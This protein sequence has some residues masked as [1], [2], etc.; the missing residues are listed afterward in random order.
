MVTS[1]HPAVCLGSWKHLL[2]YPTMRPCVMTSKT[3]I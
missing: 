1:R 3:F 2:F